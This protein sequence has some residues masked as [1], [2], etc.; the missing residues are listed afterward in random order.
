MSER[1]EQNVTISADVL[2][3]K[4]ASLPLHSLSE[5]SLPGHMLRFF[6]STMIHIT[7]TQFA[8]TSV[9]SQRKSLST[10]R[11]TVRFY[12]LLHLPFNFWGLVEFHRSLPNSG[13]F[14]KYSLTKLLA[15][16]SSNFSFLHKHFKDQQ[17]ALTFHKHY[18]ENYSVI[19]RTL[20]R[21]YGDTNDKKNS[22]AENCKHW[23]PHSSCSP[24]ITNNSLQIELSG[25]AQ[26][27][28]A[29]ACCKLPPKIT[30]H[31]CWTRIYSL[32]SNQIFI[33]Q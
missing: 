2:Y 16:T 28:Q 13:L 25:V 12:Q 20:L 29:I 23:A 18:L 19:K 33:W 8:T 32:W 5:H 10:E 17:Q 21:E 7:R 14:P 6:S 22:F 9:H 15:Q 24:C 30:Y 4:N 3:R 27:T 26:W 11:Q 31:N 1:S